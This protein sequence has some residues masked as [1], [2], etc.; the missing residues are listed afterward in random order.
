MIVTDGIISDMKETI[1][2][3]VKG[4]NLPLSIVIVGVG[5][6]DF[7]SMDILDADTQPLYSKKFQRYM[8]RDIV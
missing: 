8:S 7:S 3:I 4:S 6:T 1:D 5:D 2:M